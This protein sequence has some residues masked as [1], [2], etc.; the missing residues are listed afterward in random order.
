MTLE[1]RIALRFLEAADECNSFTH[2]YAWISPAGKL[3]EVSDHRSWAEEYLESQFN[4]D[5]AMRAAINRGDFG[6]EMNEPATYLL[7]KGWLRVTN[8]F[9]IQGKL[10][11][12]PKVWNTYMKLLLD[13]VVKKRIDPFSPRQKIGF[14][15][16]SGY[17]EF[18]IDEFVE[19]FGGK[20]WLDELF[21][22]LR[23]K[24][25]AER[26]AARFAT[27]DLELMTT[28]QIEKMANFLAG[29][30]KSMDDRSACYG[31]YTVQTA[32]EATKQMASKLRKQLT[33][34]YRDRL[35]KWMEYA[36]VKRANAG[37]GGTGI[38]KVEKG[39][40]GFVEAIPDALAARKLVKLT[41]H[42]PKQE[43]LDAKKLDPVA[44]KILGVVWND[45]K[46]DG[47]LDDQR[48]ASRT[49]AKMNLPVHWDQSDKVWFIPP[50]SKTYAVKDQLGSRGYGFRW[51][52]T[53]KRWE[54][55]KLS[56]KIKQD[57]EVK[58]AHMDPLAPAP[59]RLKGWFYEVWL[60]KNIDRFTSVFST[61]ARNLQSSY[62]IIF[63]LKGGKVA[64]KFKRKI[65]KASEAIEELRYRYINREG[66]GPWLEVLDK[67]VE[68][69]KTTDVD[70]LIRLID[71]INNLQHS[72]GL[73]ME[74]F[75]NKVQSWYMGFLNAKYHA[76]TGPDLAK[77]IP[78]R[79]LKEM[80]IWITE[81][82]RKRL[83]TIEQ[84]YRGLGKGESFEQM[85][86]K[87][88][89]SKGYPRKP[90]TKQPDRFDPDVQK[91]LGALRDY[92]SRRSA[93]IAQRFLEATT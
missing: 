19:K 5:V 32:P 46:K 22:R 86:Q 33:L 51:N 35:I 8:A 81:P 65:S 64:V 44:N 84:D 29:Q 17:K 3:I 85:M 42:L 38:K 75:P 43:Y 4:D 34:S 57:F 39:L 62:K 21:K 79:D 28:Q 50:K 47:V 56:S 13:C 23:Q 60:P 92:E 27:L 73:F 11:N 66:R 55:K 7:S 10:R 67:F 40:Q 14:E 20:N 59:E 70:K 61:Y 82:Q 88:W 93:R 45:A 37:G 30:V 78:D 53:K 31:F 49:A 54:T 71:R 72:N 1:R 24:A 52:P 2:S 87:D 48:A 91:G 77:Y 26:V 90:G 58:D 68:L 16:D 41:D 25:A 76:P 18:L 6:R 74:H 80:L 63:S 9:V 83:Q 12:S 69:V 36:L 15:H 89:R